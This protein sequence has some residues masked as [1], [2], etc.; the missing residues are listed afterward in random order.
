MSTERHDHWEAVWRDRAPDQF[1]WHQQHADRSLAIITASLD[2][3][4][5][6]RLHRLLSPAGG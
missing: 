4:D 5:A 3:L 2:R 6:S 1:S